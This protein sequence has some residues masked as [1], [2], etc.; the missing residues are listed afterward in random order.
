M[1]SKSNPLEDPDSGSK[2]GHCGFF[3]MKILRDVTSESVEGFIGD[4]LNP[5][6]ILFS[7]KNPAY[8]N[9][10]KDG[11]K[12]FQSEIFCLNHKRGFKLCSFGDK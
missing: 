2:C 9:H 1:A 8:V 10:E 5:K 12:P 11:R 3:K 6:S 4:S 7:D